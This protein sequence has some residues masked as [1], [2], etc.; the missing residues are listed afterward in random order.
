[1]DEIPEL[2]PELA[3]DLLARR[4]TL[5]RKPDVVVLTGER[6]RLRPYATADAEELHAISNGEPVTRL[7]R[8][9]STYDADELVWRFMPAGPFAG[10]SQVAQYHDFLASLEDSLVFSVV[11]TSSGELLG[12]TSYLANEPTHLK[13]EIGNVWYTPAVQGTGIN[14]EATTLLVNQAIGLGYQ[15]VEWKCH[16]ANHRSRRAAEKLGFKFEGTQDAHYI[17]KD[18]RRDTAWYRLLA[19]ECP[20]PTGEPGRGSSDVAPADVVDRTDSDAVGD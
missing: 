1:M 20:T 6:L 4:K 8:S 9:V 5:L 10:H 14:A 11:E 16:A 12:S 17:H 19:A 3:P 15:R 13:I 2:D 18:R 7:G